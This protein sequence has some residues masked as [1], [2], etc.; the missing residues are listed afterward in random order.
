[1]SEVGRD[2]AGPDHESH[3]ERAAEE[4]KRSGFLPPPLARP[5]LAASVHHVPASP[6]GPRSAL[7]ALWAILHVRNSVIGD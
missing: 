6:P 5:S 3:A 1:M 2:L 7:V 4:R